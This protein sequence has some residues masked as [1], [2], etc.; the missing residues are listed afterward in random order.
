MRCK[1][2]KISEKRTGV[3]TK[4]IIIAI[5]IL[6][7]STGIVFAYLTTRS[8]KDNNITLGYNKIELHENYT[9]PLT[10]QKG[11]S[12]TKEPYAENVG[13][14]D[15]YVRVKSVVSSS[16]VEEYLTIDYNETDY[17]Y[18]NE[19]GY[20]YYN[21]VL[22]PGENT[23]PLFTTITVSADADDIVLDGFDIYVYAESVQTVQGKTM[24]QTW[25]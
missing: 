11:I 16:L 8:G 12:F 18:N 17:T 2:A 1:H 6:M 14:V 3:V 9:P 20:W 13:S 24:Q 21:S 4:V 19:D 25:N 23:S 5:V 7:V 22:Q 15:C 10:M